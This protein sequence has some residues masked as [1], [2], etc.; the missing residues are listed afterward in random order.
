MGDQYYVYQCSELPT[1]AA[2]SSRY[3]V[4][5]HSLEYIRRQLSDLEDS[6][7]TALE[8]WSV[9][10]ALGLMPLGQDGEIMS[11]IRNPEQAQSARPTVQTPLRTAW[12]SSRLR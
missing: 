8:T 11:G 1:A 10:N 2:A 4:E 5:N 6:S 7:R 3:E 12:K 9:R